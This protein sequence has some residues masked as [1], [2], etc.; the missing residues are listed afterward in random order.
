M[1]R[2]LDAFVSDRKA[3]EVWTAGLGYIL[4]RE[5]DTVRALS[6]SFTGAA[7]LARL[8]DPNGFF[9]GAPDFGAAILTP[10][11][12]LCVMETKVRMFLRAGC[13]V[14]WIVDPEAATLRI[15]RPE[16]KTKLLTLNDEADAEPALPGFRCSVRALFGH[17]LAAP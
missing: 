4:E 2:R 11:D 16:A 12:S 14:A 13:Q 10:T 1:F 7:A 5:P 17:A 15:Y 8:A 9:P 3:G 6:V